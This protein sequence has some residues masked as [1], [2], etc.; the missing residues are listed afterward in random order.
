MP[1][2][3]SADTRTRIFLAADEL[4]CQHGYEG[5]SVRDVAQRADVNKA[6]VFYYFSSKEELFEE[7]L[8]KYFSASREAMQDALESGGTVRERMHRLIEDYWAFMRQ[9]SQ[10]SKLV[11]GLLLS[12]DEYLPSVQ[13]ALEPLFEWT[14]EVVSEVSPSEGPTAA[15]QLY[16]TFAGAVTTHF[17]Y[18]PALEPG[19]GDDPLSD[20]SMEERRQHLHWLVD[21]MLD[22]LIEG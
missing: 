12:G 5:V 7:V 21:L 9:N 4:F 19:W 11:Q 18:A 17:T 3:Q 10:Y 20:A 8:Q 22:E 15:R 14:L 2:E 1:D 6:S 13:R 16:V